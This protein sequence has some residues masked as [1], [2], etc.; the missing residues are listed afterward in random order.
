MDSSSALLFFI[1]SLLLSSSSMADI[2][3]HY[4]GSRA[5]CTLPF[6][7]DFAESINCTISCMKFD[8]LSDSDGTRVV[9]RGCGANNTNLCESTMK[10]AGA[11]GTLCNCNTQYCNHESKTS[12]NFSALF[13]SLFAFIFMMFGYEL[14]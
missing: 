2:P 7:S 6:N 9:I 11:T 3:C 13:F 8:G 10:M 5:L 12:L 4:C 1:G 14:L